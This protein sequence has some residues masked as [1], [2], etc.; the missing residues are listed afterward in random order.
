[1]LTTSG[2]NTAEPMRQYTATNITVS[3]DHY[4]PRGEGPPSA[5]PS[6]HDPGP[7]PR[8]RNAAWMAPV[9]T[10]RSRQHANHRNTHHRG[11]L[12]PYRGQSLLEGE[13]GLVVV[14]SHV[15]HDQTGLRYVYFVD[16]FHARYDGLPRPASSRAPTTGSTNRLASGLGDAGG[17]RPLHAG[18]GRRPGGLCNAGFPLALA[19]RGL[20]WPSLCCLRGSPPFLAA[21][22]ADPPPRPRSRNLSTSRCSSNYAPPGRRPKHCKHG[23]TQNIEGGSG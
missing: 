8:V 4:S 22:G 6:S 13:G 11:G 14:G 16:H 21:V 17:K 19:R 5:V 7:F 23:Q 3:K 2:S 1:M 10:A 12:R 15:D 9:A 20:P 18:A